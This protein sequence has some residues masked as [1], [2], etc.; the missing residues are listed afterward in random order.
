MCSHAVCFRDVAIVKTLITCAD[1]LGCVPVE[2]DVAAQ[3]LKGACRGV[4]GA[5]S[6]DDMLSDHGNTS[7][8]GKKQRTSSISGEQI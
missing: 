6:L 8:T 4:L 2:V 5:R 3:G 1:E 7:T